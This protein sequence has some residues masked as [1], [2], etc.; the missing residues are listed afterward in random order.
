MSQSAWQ[1][2]LRASW[3]FLACWA[4]SGW[5][6][7]PPWFLGTTVADQRDRI[8][9][10]A[11]GL[12]AFACGRH[13]LA[14]VAGAG[15][16]RALWAPALAGAWRKVYVITALAALY[17]NLFVGV[18]QTFEK[19]PALKA[20]DPTRPSRPFMVTQLAVLILAVV[21]ISAAGGN[22]ASEQAAIKKR[23]SCMPG[24][25]AAGSPSTCRSRPDTLLTHLPHE[26][27]AGRRVPGALELR[28]G[29]SAPVPAS[30]QHPQG[31]RAPWQW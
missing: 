17:L 21:L 18:V 8:S 27:A 7:G 4:E 6:A 13:P 15:D 14:P 30:L 22:F 9:A 31:N 20:M 23:R 12:N 16:L 26:R 1:D 3:S 29:A 10:S 2:S 25:T 24:R 28:D 5:T 11:H 19:V